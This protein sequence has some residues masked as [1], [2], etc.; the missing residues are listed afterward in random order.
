MGGDRFFP[1]FFSYFFQIAGSRAKG[2][3]NEYTGD[4]TGQT[5]RT[6]QTRHPRQTSQTTQTR[7][8]ETSTRHTQLDRR[9]RHEQARQTK[10]IKTDKTDRQTDTRT[11][12]LTDRQTNRTQTRRAKVNRWMSA[13]RCIEPATTHSSQV[14]DANGSTPFLQKTMTAAHTKLMTANGEYFP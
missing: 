8:T 2:K 14:V 7:Q 3:Y 11:C 13:H 10:T 4:R 12:K 6:D 1:N 9:D 5:D